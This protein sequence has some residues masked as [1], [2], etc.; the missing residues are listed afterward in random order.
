MITRDTQPPVA[1]FSAYLPACLPAFEAKRN[2][3]ATINKLYVDV[4]FNVNSAEDKEGLLGGE[5]LRKQLSV[6]IEKWIPPRPVASSFC[7]QL[8]LQLLLA[9]FFS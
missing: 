4:N 5:S 8:H 6:S 3:G 7:L 1:C 9:E 2:A